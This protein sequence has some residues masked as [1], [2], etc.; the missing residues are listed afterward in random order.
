MNTKRER[1]GDFRELLG[2]LVRVPKKEFELEAAKHEAK[3]PKKKAAKRN[4]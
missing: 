1:I 2:K 4:K 3:K